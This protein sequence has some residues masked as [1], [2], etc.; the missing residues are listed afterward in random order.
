VF[1]NVLTGRTITAP[2]LKVTAV[3]AKGSMPQAPAG[4]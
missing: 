1:T 3:E 2:E 4:R